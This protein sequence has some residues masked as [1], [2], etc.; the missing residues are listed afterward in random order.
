[1]KMKSTILAMLALSIF[2]AVAV[3]P[4]HATTLPPDIYARTDKPSYAPG[5]SGIL[6]ITVRNVGTQAI[7]IQNLSI[8]YPWKAFITNHW[9]GNFTTTGISQPI[10]QDQTYNTQYSFTLPTDGRV[11]SILGGTIQIGVGTDIGSSS[12]TTG[13]TYTGSATISYA[14]ATYQP[15]DL[16]ISVLPIIE[17]ALLGVAV[18]MLALVFLRI[19]KLS[20]K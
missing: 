10:A 18:V 19:N 16:S 8:T 15:L 5:D 17:I 13:T 12:S 6:Y 11:S 7:T 9:D 20:K 14:L 3:T 2:A 4:S 1:M